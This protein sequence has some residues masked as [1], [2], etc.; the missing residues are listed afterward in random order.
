MYDLS[1][2]LLLVVTMNRLLFLYIQ[3]DSI[4]E[5]NSLYQGI[6]WPPGPK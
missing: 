3:A 6:I 4:E 2:D 1:V 5:K